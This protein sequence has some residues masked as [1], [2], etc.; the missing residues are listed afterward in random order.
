MERYKN[1]NLSSKERAED[2]LLRM[3]D[4]EK[5]AQMDMTRGVEF[6]TKVHSA[7]FCA[8]DPESD[9]HWDMVEEVIGKNG[10]GFVHDTYSAPRVLNM[11]QRYMVEKTRLGIPCIF[12][13]EALHGV[14][15]PG[16]TVFP[17]PIAQGA[18]F[19]PDLTHE[20]GHAIAT[21]ARS[22]GVCEILAPNLDL[23]REPRWGRTEETF[24]EDTYLSSQMA[25]AIIT[26]EQGTDLSVPDA[27][28]AEPK[29]YCV[30]GIPEGGLN[31][32]PARVGRREVETA[33]LPVFEAGIKK[34]GAYNA[35]ASYNCIDGEAVISSEHYLREVL[36]ERYGMRG[37]VRADFGAVS[38][39]KNTHHMTGSNLES[40]EAAVNG[41][42]DVQGFDFPNKEWQGGIVELL[43]AGRISRKTIDDAVLRIL[44]LKF[45]LGLF[46]DPYV[47]EDAYKDKIRCDRH[48]EISYK[49]AQESI[50][51]IKNEN[52]IL[53]LS[54]NIK[55]IA[56]TGPGAGKQRLGSYSSKPYGYR[57][58]SLV[59]ELT[60]Y[61]PDCEINYAPGCGITENE[62]T[63]IPTSWF[64]NGVDM[65]FYNNDHFGGDPVGTAHAENINFD[66]AITKPHKDLE[67]KG[68]SAVFKTRIKINT[69]DIA[70]AESFIGRLVFVCHDSVRIKI[71]GEYMIESWGAHKKPVPGCDFE[72][73]N[74]A[75][76]D[77]EIEFVC[78]VSGIRL[79][80]CVDYNEENIDKAVAAAEKSDVAIVVCGDNQ[81]TSGEGMDR[82]DLKLYGR[83]NELIERVSKTGTPVV[84]VLQCGKPVDIFKERNFAEGIIISWFGGEFG[85]KAIRD[86]LFGEICPGGKLPVSFPKSVGHLPCYYSMLPGGSPAYLEGDRGALYPFGFGL[87]YTSFEY[88]NLK[89]EK[90][91]RYDYTVS[92]D[93]TNTGDADGDEIVQLYV[94]DICS[95]I[96]TP[97]LLLKGFRRL[98]LKAG[99]C[100]TAVMKL[101]FDS[102]KLLDKSFKWVVEPGK[103]SIKI[104]ASSSDIRLEEIIEID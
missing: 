48:K 83:Q 23:S 24:G 7:H 4:E 104:G 31:C 1:K 74:G 82:C 94:E 86:V 22:I 99:E 77:I 60:D 15:L 101:D 69:Y 39:L 78:D 9:Y 42:L 64:V 11:M 32:S 18:S 13:G 73:V 3:T 20:I 96:V 61:L 53:P 98:S 65:T 80:L 2:L 103:F 89:I 52:N 10:I 75:V 58:R 37:Y 14:S 46:D 12:T 41:G 87:S 36:K 55:S 29:H 26:G 93:V 84:L 47:D 66:W 38:R 95:S 72:F 91:G 33:Y 50:V 21:E 76:H 35:M 6:A 44:T 97:P 88:S 5:A 28:A 62:T 79:T 100:K 68:Y 71:D 27:V 30:H 59:E 8:I 19:D 90:H 92:V 25:Y 51:L 56:L 49:S 57:P 67:F 16:A 81:V 54:R 45:E 34:A 17:M 102:F 40:I 70:S 63:V 85:A 43:K